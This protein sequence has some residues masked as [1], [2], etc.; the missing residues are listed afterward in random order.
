MSLN[1]TFANDFFTVN[2]PPDSFNIFYETEGEVEQ[3]IVYNPGDQGPYE[4]TISNL[5]ANSLYIV[6][7][8]VV[9]PQGVSGKSLEVK[10]ITCKLSNIF[11]YSIQLTLATDKQTII[12]I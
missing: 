7:V 3:Q 9:T 12:V 11:Q 5:P 6:T 2:G 8:D 1:V 4:I 10:A